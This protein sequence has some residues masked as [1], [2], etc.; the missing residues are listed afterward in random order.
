MATDTGTATGN[1]APRTSLTARGPGNRK[2]GS[3]AYRAWQI[4]GF[5]EGGNVPDWVGVAEQ[6][7][8]DLF[9]ANGL[10][11]RH[12]PPTRELTADE[13]AV[14]RFFAFLVEWLWDDDERLSAHRLLEEAISRVGDAGW[15]GDWR[16]DTLHLSLWSRDVMK[17]ARCHTRDG[18]PLD[19][20]ET[21]EGEQV[22]PHE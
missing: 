9:R 20:T 12:F 14:W 13:C 11:A 7:L 6:C 17:G 16:G 8:K 10:S 18:Y 22:A 3:R 19:P 2:P 1:I 15:F 5:Y 21:A 4:R